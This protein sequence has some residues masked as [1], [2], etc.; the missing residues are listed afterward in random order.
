V[1]RENIFTL[2]IGN[3]SLRQDNNDSGVRIVHSAKSKN[4]IFKKKMFPH[5][6]IHKYTWAFPVGKTH[7]KIDHIDREEIAFEYIRFTKFQWS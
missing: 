3:E 2:T 4:L 1:G 6:D 7:N 5:R